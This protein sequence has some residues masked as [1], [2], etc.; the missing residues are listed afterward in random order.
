M[1]KTL[2]QP[3]KTHGGKKYLAKRII[4]LFPPHLHYVEP[5]F[6]GGAVLLA[7]DP[8][9]DW[10][11]D[12]SWKLKYGDKVPSHLRGCSEVVSDINGILICFWRTMQS[13]ERFADFQRTVSAVPFS[14]REYEEAY[15][16]GG[17][18]YMDEYP[19]QSSVGFFIRARQSMAGRGDC[20]TPLT[21]NRTRGGRNAEAN[22]WW[23]CIEGLPEVHE[24]L[25]GVVILNDDACKV[26]R[27][28]DG[29]KT[30]FYVDPP[31]MHETRS[32]TGEYGEFEMSDEQHENLL[33]CLSTIKG[34]FILS[35][36]WST[37]YDK[38]AYEES[39]HRVDIEIDNKASSAKTKKKETEC[40]WANFK[41]EESD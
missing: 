22:A 35:G 32:S 21:R 17:V 33:H 16:R 1:S 7:R 18:N 23:N 37:L 11:I 24:R 38:I 13:L 29:D 20:F 5:F 28:Q 3:L 14:S 27:Q 19:V 12:E 2:T 8:N 10:F 30:L 4:S 39:W 15:L 25:K 9:R 6:G 36:Y 41:I 40:L 31:Y 34:K 26:I